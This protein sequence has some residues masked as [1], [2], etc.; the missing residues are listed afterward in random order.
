[1]C[2]IGAVPRAAVTPIMGVG[3]LAAVEHLGDAG[4]ETHIDLLADGDFGALSTGICSLCAI[5]ESDRASRHSATAQLAAGRS[6]GAAR[7]SASNKGSASFVE[8]RAL[9]RQ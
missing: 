9:H 7:S 1:M 8:G 4:R 2:E 5:G 3:A 6:C